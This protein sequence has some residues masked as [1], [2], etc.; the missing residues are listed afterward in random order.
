MSLVAI[1]PARL[2]S[3]ENEEAAATEL[4]LRAHAERRWLTTQLAPLL[5]ELEREGAVPESG[6]SAALGCLQ[7]LWGSELSLAAQ[8][9]AAFLHLPAGAAA[10]GARGF[11]DG[12]RTLRGEV[13][14]RTEDL[15]RPAT[16]R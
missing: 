7:A 5:D 15:L 6:R 10:D 13:G 14:R 11:H 9:E 2:R 16:G 3:T 1:A 8:T 4:L 12:V